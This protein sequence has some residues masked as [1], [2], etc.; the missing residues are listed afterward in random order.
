M[1]L[2]YGDRTNPLLAKLIEGWKAE[3][4]TL[5]ARNDSPLSFKK[6]MALRGRIAQ[7]KAHI[8]LGDETPVILD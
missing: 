1:T 3:L 8:A 2:D 7:L 6:T 4:A 5:R